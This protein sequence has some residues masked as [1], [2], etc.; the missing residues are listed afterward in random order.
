M[1]EVENQEPEAIKRRTDL[2]FSN[3]LLE[4]V[5]ISNKDLI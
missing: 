5:F 4:P 3:Q 1:E 2:N